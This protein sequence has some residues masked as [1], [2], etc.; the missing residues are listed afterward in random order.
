MQ[1]ILG[2]RPSMK[3]RLATWWDL[4]KQTASEFSDD[5]ASRIGAA[6]AYYT[7]FSIAPIV[8]VAVS[9]AGLVFGEEAAQGQ[10]STQLD[11]LLGAQAADMVETMVQNTN[12]AGGGVFATVVGL[13]TLVIGASSV[14]VQLRGALNAMWDVKPEKTG[15]VAAIL[16]QALSF[17]MVVSLG[18]LLMVSLVVSALLSGLA[19][20]IETWLDVPAVVLQVVNQGISLAVITVLFAGV[21]KF[22]P[23]TKIAW[24]DV[25]VGALATAVLFSIGKF[26]IGQYLGHSSVASTYGAAGSLVVLLVWVYYSAQ[27]ILFGAEFTQ[28]YARHSGSHKYMRPLLTLGK[29]GGHK[30]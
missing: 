5:N 6:L 27:L 26:A 3:T 20:W 7:V 24:S 2:T 29:K 19:G 23:A 30:H 8:V 4:L 21:Y 25:F 1:K 22:L 16:T 13:V 10:L 18:F 9:V 12:K 14:F 15:I 28:V 11:T 17:A